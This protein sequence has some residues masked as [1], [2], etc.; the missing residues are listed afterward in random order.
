MKLS[1]LKSL[2]KEELRGILKEN[3]RDSVE[4]LDILIN[5][6]KRKK[7]ADV[8][9]I[10]ENAK[11]SLEFDDLDQALDESVETFLDSKGGSSIYKTQNIRPEY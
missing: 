2:I 1:E 6:L 10:L 7:Y 9:V 8:L 4:N 3:Y 5:L 11:D